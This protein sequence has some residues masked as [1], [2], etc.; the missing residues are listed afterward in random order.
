M[1][2]YGCKIS[3]DFVCIAGVM[4]LERAKSLKG[5]TEILTLASA[6]L[7]VS[8]YKFNQPCPVFVWNNETHPGLLM[9]NS[10]AGSWQF[11]REDVQILTCTPLT[12]NK[13]LQ[14]LSLSEEA[15][16]VSG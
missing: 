8:A 15:R 14:R 1:G 3:R 2:P 5:S 10:F 12:I 6:M 7:E 11:E 16:K 13:G 9:P 4:R